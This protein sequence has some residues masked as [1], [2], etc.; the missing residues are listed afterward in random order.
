MTLKDVGIAILFG[1]VVFLVSMFVISR[2]A[3]AQDF[4]N[5]CGHGLRPSPYD[6]RC[7]PIRRYYAQPRPHYHHHHHQRHVEE[8]R[9]ARPHGYKPSGHEHYRTEH[10][11]PG[12]LCLEKDVTVVSDLHKG[13]PRSRADAI[14][15]WQAMVQWSG[16]G[17]EF[18]NF[19][20]ARDP[21]WRCDIADAHDS[22]LGKVSQA[23]G[24]ATAAVT[25]NDDD[26]QSIRCQ[27][28][29]KP[30]RAP[31]QEGDDRRGRR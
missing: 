12:A 26:G 24:R 21:D 19:A 4:I 2:M 7:I 16:G 28:W 8:R 11:G 5:Y 29:A 25:G 13:E 6:G 18:M 9:D 17:G 31:R 1:L 20:N 23:V 3:Q 22:Y 27:V 10:Q 30:C 15:K 14:K